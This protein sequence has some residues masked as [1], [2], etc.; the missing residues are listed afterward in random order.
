MG[1]LEI[2]GGLVL[3]GAIAGIIML[4]VI[5]YD[6]IKKWLN[7]ART[8]HLNAQFAALIRK[9][10]S[11]GRHS[12]ISGIFDDQGTQFE[13]QEWKGKE[14]DPELKKKFGWRKEI[15]LDLDTV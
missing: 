13:T 15:I 9:R 10:L 1:W 2:L 4:V 5:T 3:G 12:V 14:L 7:E 11:D 8:R 6:I